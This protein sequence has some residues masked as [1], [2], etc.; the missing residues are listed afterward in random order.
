MSFVAKFTSTCFFV[1]RCKAW[2]CQLA[3]ARTLADE[4]ASY[5]VLGLDGPTATTEE[6]KKAYRDLAASNSRTACV[7]QI[8]HFFRPGK[9]AL[10]SAQG[11]LALKEHPDK[12]AW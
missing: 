10:E 5:F 12:A 2:T 8:W 11:A 7:L 1:R 9:L 3:A 4:C 6:I